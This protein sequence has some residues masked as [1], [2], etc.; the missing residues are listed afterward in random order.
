MVTAFS[1]D[2][3]N[4]VKERLLEGF[5]YTE[6]NQMTGVSNAKISEVKNKVESELGKTDFE[7]VREFAKKIRKNN[8][9]WSELFCANMINSYIKK[10]GIESSTF[11]SFVKNLYNECSKSNLKPQEIIQYGEKLFS[12]EQQ[13]GIALEDLP[14]ECQNLIN[15]K[16][17]LEKQINQL[18]QDAKESKNNT[19][20]IL[21]ENRLTVEKLDV[22][23]KSKIILENAGIT[24]DDYSKL[25]T[26]FQNIKDINYDEKKIIT[27]LEKEEDHEQALENIRHKSA[28][29]ESK[30]ATLLA[31]NENLAVTISAQESLI[32][33]LDNLVKLGITDEHLDILCSVVLDIAK[34]N[35]MDAKKAFDVLCVD[36]ENNYDKII[37]LK[38][39]LAKLDNDFKLK[40]KE[41]EVISTKIENHKLKYK[42]EQN[43]IAIIKSLKQKIN[44]QLII[45]WNNIFDKANLNPQDFEKQLNNTGNLE[46]VI[47]SKQQT[48]THLTHEQKELKLNIETL[49]GC[50][51]ELESKIMYEGKL[52]E[53]YLDSFIHR[54]SNQ[55]KIVSDIGIKSIVDM[56]QTSRNGI[57]NVSTKAYDEMKSNFEE[58][59]NL[60]ES[61]GE[62]ERKIGKIDA[63]V[64]LFNLTE[65]FEPVKLYPVIIVILNNLITQI[66]KYD[67]NSSLLYKIKELKDKM[68]EELSK[69]E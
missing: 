1:S 65:K 58:I 10:L 13:L 7:T 5:S 33:Q 37:G 6:I 46:K 28:E 2:T 62:A 36:I 19:Q 69:I 67:K 39:D 45:T 29:S 60:M 4:K 20:R 52:I 8:S 9:S 55:I 51:S 47:T 31:K 38:S 25:A 40:S 64:P 53:K 34:S 59:Q 22:F 18:N 12:L 43:I 54:A 26:V 21:D 24:F 68:I 15:K 30:N 23:V 14:K 50:K 17:S 41:I 27:Y 61:L 42:E 63:F 44:P 56:T 32:L 16:E 35:N 49:E 57:K 48:I 3:I 11:E 66:Q